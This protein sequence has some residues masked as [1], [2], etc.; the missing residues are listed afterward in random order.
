MQEPK[1]R[2]QEAMNPLCFGGKQV[3]TPENISMLITFG[4]FH[5]TRTEYIT[6]DIVDMKYPYNEIIG[7]GTLNALKP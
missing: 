2:L 6:F 4:Y 1:N 5:N 3:T 7:R